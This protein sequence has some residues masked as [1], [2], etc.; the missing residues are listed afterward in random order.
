MHLKANC[1][2]GEHASE[3]LVGL[4]AADHAFTSLG[5]EYAGG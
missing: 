1:P 3:E 2:A 5:L 4:V